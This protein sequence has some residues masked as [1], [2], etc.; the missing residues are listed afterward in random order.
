MISGTSYECIDRTNL[1]SAG[2]RR[3]LVFIMSRAS[4]LFCTWPFQRKIEVTDGTRL[5]HAATLLLI[6]ASAILPASR[7]FD[8]MTNTTNTLCDDALI[9]YHQPSSAS[10]VP[11]LETK[12]SHIKL[13]QIVTFNFAP[14]QPRFLPV[15]PRR[16]CVKRQ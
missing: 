6:A 1:A 10:L 5:A 16:T 7:R 13:N 11:Y 12:M 2:Y 4:R 14:S 8:V 9:N 3:A 15:Y